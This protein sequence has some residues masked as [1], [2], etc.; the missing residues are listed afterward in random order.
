MIT[1][2]LMQD[3][4]DHMIV[5][6]PALGA[7]SYMGLDGNYDLTLL[8]RVLSL[9][10]VIGSASAGAAQHGTCVSQ[11]LHFPRDLLYVPE[12]CRANF[13]LALHHIFLQSKQRC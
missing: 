3:V 9:L 12:R 7:S 13:L 2:S 4:N 11:F 5:E 1:H 8:Q 10:T 6:N